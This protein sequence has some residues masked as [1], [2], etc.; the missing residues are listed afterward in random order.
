MKAID[1]DDDGRAL[2]AFEAGD[3]AVEDVVGGPQ[4]LP[5]GVAVGVASLC[6]DGVPTFGCQE[7][8][9]FGS[10]PSCSVRS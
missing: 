8:N 3:G 4:V 9:V 5:V 7:S 10:Q 2:E 1:G 6:V